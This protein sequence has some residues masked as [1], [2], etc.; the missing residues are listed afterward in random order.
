MR[1]FSATFAPAPIPRR[2]RPVLYRAFELR[3]RPRRKKDIAFG[4]RLF[5]IAVPHRRLLREPDQAVRRRPRVFVQ[6]AAFIQPFVLPA[7]RRAP[8]QMF[9][10]LRRPL[11]R[12]AVALPKQ[13]FEPPW[14]RRRGAPFILFQPIPAFLRRFV[15]RYLRRITPVPTF[16]LPL[17]ID[18]DVV[19]YL[20]ERP[21]ARDY[22]GA[23]PG[24]GERILPA[25]LAARTYL[26]ASDD[27]TNYL[28]VTLGAVAW[29]R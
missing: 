2:V 12:L 18:I 24:L 5:A 9:A 6:T 28:G 22:L 26:G 4:K 20:G 15:R 13:P 14:P 11:R 19:D 10:P 21:R 29:R 8:S 1:R 3:E 23:E 25:T 27:R 16:T 7:L 17:V